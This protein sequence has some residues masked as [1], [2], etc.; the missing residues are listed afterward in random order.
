MTHLRLLAAAPIAAL[1]TLAACQSEPETVGQAKDPMAEEL[2]NAPPVELPPAMVARTYR[3]SDNSL[4]YAD[5][6][7]DGQF[8]MIGTS[9]TAKVR[10]AAAE[11]NRNYSGEG[12]TISANAEDTRIKAPGKS[13]Q[14]CRSHNR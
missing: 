11:A 13:E 10:A 8:A 6:S 4:I 9:Q 14:S 12:Y 7:A 1:L 3:C 2:K 5:F